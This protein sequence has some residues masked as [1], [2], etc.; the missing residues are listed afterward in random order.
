[1]GCLCLFLLMD[2]GDHAWIGDRYE[3]GCSNLFSWGHT[4]KHRG[5]LGLV[6]A[7]LNRSRTL[8]VRKRSV[9]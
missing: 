6:W 4:Q 9:A 1:M 5:S 3:R 8:F 7:A 2:Y